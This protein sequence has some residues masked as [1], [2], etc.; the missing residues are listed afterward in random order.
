MHACACEKS[1]ENNT[2]SIHTI[3]G[4]V[5]A[6]IRRYKNVLAIHED[7]VDT[8]FKQNSK[9]FDSQKVCGPIIAPA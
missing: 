7:D 1:Y 4:R 3:S 9:L 2:V 6:V 8:F 5:I